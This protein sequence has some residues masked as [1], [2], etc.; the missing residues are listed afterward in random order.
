M[1][2]R[3]LGFLLVGLSSFFLVNSANAT[4][5]WARFSCSQPVGT[6]STVT[7]NTMEYSRS[8]YFWNTNTCV[9]DD[10]LGSLDFDIINGSAV[11]APNDCLLW[12]GESING[13]TNTLTDDECFAAG[14]IA[15][16][17]GGTSYGCPCLA[18]ACV[19]NFVNNN[20][21]MKESHFT[22]V[23]TCTGTSCDSRDPLGYV[24]GTPNYEAVPAYDFQLNG[25]AVL[26]D[27]VRVQ[28]YSHNNAKEQFPGDD[29][30][31]NYMAH[32]TNIQLSWDNGAHTAQGIITSNDATPTT[33][34]SPTVILP[35]LPAG[36]QY[37][38]VGVW[39][40]Y[41]NATVAGSP[42]Y[43]ADHFTLNDAEL[44]VN[45][46]TATFDLG[47]HASCFGNIHR[48][49][50]DLQV[51]DIPDPSFTMTK[52]ANPDI[53]TILY[54][55]DS[56]S[57]SIMV[58]NTG[59]T[60][61]PNFNATDTLDTNLTF[62]SGDNGVSHVNG[63]VTLDFNNIVVGESI[64]KSFVVTVNDNTPSGTDVCNQAN[65]TNSGLVNESNIICHNVGE[66]L[67]PDFSLVK[68]ANPPHQSTVLPGET[69]TYTVTAN[70]EGNTV[71]SNFIATD[72]L[73][74]SV[75]FVSGDTGV[76]HSNGIV[77]LNFGDISIG[78]NAT[79]SFQVTVN[80]DVSVGD[81]ISNR[82]SATYENITHHSNIIH[83]IV[84][85]TLVPD[86]TITKSANP[87][88]LSTLLPEETLTYTI[89]TENTGNTDLSNIV[90]TDVLNSNLIPSGTMP[91][92]MSY[93]PNTHTITITIATLEPGA[94]Q[95]TS[96]STMVIENP[97]T[98]IS[99]CNI[100]TGINS[101][102]L[103]R[104]SNEVCHQIEAEPFTDF[105]I[106]KSANP[107]HQSLLNP[108][109]I[110][111][112]T[113]STENTGDTTLSN[114]VITDVLNSN[115]SFTDIILPNYLS[116]DPNTHTVTITIATL[117]P[118]ASQETSFS[119][120][121][122]E[123]PQTNISFCNIATGIDSTGLNRQ[124]NEVCH[125]I[126][127]EPFT[128]FSITKSA[129]PPHLA[130]LL[131]G[132]MLTYTIST[133]NTGNTALSNI[134]ITDVLSPYVTFSEIMPSNVSYDPD[135]HTLTIT[136]ATL[137]PGETQSLSFSVTINEDSPTNISFCNKASGV[138][139]TGMLRSSEDICHSVV[140]E[141]V[142]LHKTAN[143]PEDQIV[144]PGETLTYTVS[145]TNNTSENLDIIITDPLDDNLSFVGFSN[146]SNIE[147]DPQTHSVQI[148]LLNVPGFS[149][150]PV[151][152]SVMVL[153]P[154]QE[155]VKVCNQSK[156]LSYAINN[157]SIPDD[158]T[159]PEIY[160]NNGN[161]GN[162]EN[163]NVWDNIIYG[164]Q[165]FFGAISTIF[166]NLTD[167]VFDIQTLNQLVASSVEMPIED[168]NDNNE[169]YSE[170][171]CHLVDISAGEA[172]EIV[173]TSDPIPSTPELET[174]VHF[175]DSIIYSVRVTNHYGI[176]I[177]ESLVDEIDLG[178]SFVEAG[179]ISSTDPNASGEIIRVDDQTLHLNIMNLGN[180]ETII[181]NFT[182]EVIATVDSEICNQA[183][184]FNF[185]SNDYTSENICV[186]FSDGS[187]ENTFIEKSVSP[188]A[189]PIA[190]GDTLSYTVRF[191]SDEIMPITTVL[192]DT[193]DNTVFV[194]NS[195]SITSSDSSITG[196]IT[197]ETLTKTLSLYVNDLTQGGWIEFRFDALVTSDSLPSEI[198]NQAYDINE[199][200][201]SNI[202]CVSTDT[203]GG[204]GP[205]GGE[206]I[207]T[208]GICT[209]LASGSVTCRKH[210]PHRSF[211]E[212]EYLD[213]KEC[214]RN[215][216][217]IAGIELCTREW[218]RSVGL[219]ALGECHPDN[220]AAAGTW[221][222]WNGSDNLYTWP[223]DFNNEC[224]TEI[225]PPGP[226]MESCAEMTALIEKTTSTPVVAK[227]EEAIYNLKLTLTPDITDQNTEINITGMKVYD[228]TIPAN[229]G[230]LFDHALQNPSS[231]WEW[232]GMNDD[233]ASNYFEW[234]GSDFLLETEQTMDI[235]YEMNT[236]L[237]IKAD[238]AQVNNVAFAVVE[239]EIQTFD[240]FSGLTALSGP[241]HLHVGN[242][243]NLC[244]NRSVLEIIDASTSSPGSSET[245]EIIRPYI[246]VR[247]GGNVGVQKLDDNTEN[248]FGGLETGFSEDITT[249]E[250]LTGTETDDLTET[251]DLWSEYEDQS[252]TTENIFGV[253]WI[254]TSDNAGV[255][256]HEGDIT[257]SA[258]DNFVG[259]K[260]FVI[261]G[262]LQIEGNFEP[263]GFGAFI[264]DRIAIQQ[265]VTNM[266]GVFIADGGDIVSLGESDK[267]LVISGALM[268]D[269]TDLLDR[270]K[271]IGVD[272][273][274][275]LEP[276]IKIN[277]DLRLLDAT[278]PALELFLSEDWTQTIE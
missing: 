41:N 3:S 76:S 158:N 140:E 122:I 224:N 52:T 99:F 148:T 153:H 101:T 176:A 112:Y 64:T 146:S 170:R 47:D 215:N 244:D 73:I 265:D 261:D 77:T 14:L 171:I 113:I 255:Y 78:G 95:E 168:Q 127:A 278:P 58:N 206:V 175:G 161:T 81:Q 142:T 115:L 165:N 48:V 222:Q 269:A 49:Y 93:D 241:R 164:V 229:S 55:G 120:M 268:G 235:D 102:G 245:V 239:Y 209:D 124:S 123:N 199:N 1:K 139:S 257:L 108:G 177:S 208:I 152:F 118:G 56:L 190:N 188:A 251:I 104:Q 94:S 174:I 96:F 214:K 51:T 50:F 197:Y 210:T 227:E 126:E 196:S 267:Q 100:A 34:T 184:L 212:S 204:P 37:E 53:N 169:S 86:F 61:L 137:E 119:T 226:C 128:D 72:N 4:C 166:G 234:R 228:L 277:Y 21:R 187:S 38:L 253:N 90:I 67:T 40:H 32:A 75:S 92:N 129:N 45:G 156:V 201:Y 162:T 207:S 66:I 30:Y 240:P 13:E 216:P 87:P 83:H 134:V 141:F 144:T 125:Q 33:K 276:S 121:V 6:D 220:I 11:S 189:G 131:P 154:G 70:N 231:N 59:N 223:G 172:I 110:L 194:E 107:P 138:D 31:D 238:T 185:H 182:T 57:Y 252:T 221:W 79:K 259:S 91:N 179:N 84:G 150:V 19:N 256:F 5:T 98:N 243:L 42:S 250:I 225:I 111:D 25:A 7:F 63:V 143:I 130:T 274:N 103:N 183:Q 180:D 22:S 273:E 109:N 114:I 147:Y 60:V 219:L 17:I 20:D 213:W 198:C 263:D 236:A 211:G 232:K 12:R 260:T 24:P 54:P 71:L 155:N 135:T 10:D 35:T 26:G 44:S 43:V 2:L 275:T 163:R 105:S 145:A 191:V 192:L 262:K 27:K 116:Y 62:V 16:N 159:E 271:F 247:G 149:T 254:T 186:T 106:T 132:D 28:V 173:K 69:I 88:H 264:A 249:G 217:T 65:A 248:P 195:G 133:E 258:S 233:P 200:W 29:D 9:S 151:S 117:E 23:R 246:E 178:L 18:S 46:T 160:G 270:R 8:K 205:G 74:P 68:S 218:A 272:P 15:T 136:I 39:H 181:F 202:V 167:S 237:T 230:W 89:S 242:A 97:Q 85:E 193:L 203:G 80:D 157:G 82:A 36:K 266:T